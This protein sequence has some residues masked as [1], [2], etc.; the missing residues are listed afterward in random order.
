MNLS[1][2][3]CKALDSTG[4]SAIKMCI[5]DSPGA[6]QCIQ[7]KAA[8]VHGQAATAHAGVFQHLQSAGAV[9]YTHLDV[10]KRQPEEQ[11][12]L[13]G[14]EKLNRRKIPVVSGHP[15]DLSLIHI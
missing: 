13:A 12:Y 1:K 14:I 9:S 2:H 6:V 4:K 10:Y 11:E 5:R 3:F 7:R 8:L 15:W